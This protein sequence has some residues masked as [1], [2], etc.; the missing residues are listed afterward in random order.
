M[1]TDYIQDLACALACANSPA[2]AEQL[3]FDLLD[4]A[5]GGTKTVRTFAEKGILSYNKGVVLGSAVLSIQV[6]DDWAE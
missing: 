5:L 6:R 2:E 4:A 3:L 1:D